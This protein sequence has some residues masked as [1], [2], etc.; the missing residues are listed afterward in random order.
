MIGGIILAKPICTF[1]SE[2]QFLNCAKEWQHRLFLDSWNI[3]F[4]LTNNT[5]S[6][7]TSEDGIENLLWGYCSYTFENSGAVITVF[8]GKVLECDDGEVSKNIAELTL[9]HELLHVKLEYMSDKDIIGDIPK[10][11][12]SLLHQGVERMAKSLIMTKYNLDYDYFKEN[13]MIVDK[14]NKVV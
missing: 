13:P 11:H 5:I 2:E 12:Q 10:L 1:K 7:A 9:V 6:V 14:A 8:N 3:E 4:K